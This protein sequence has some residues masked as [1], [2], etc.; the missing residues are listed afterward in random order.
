MG[1]VVTEK[2]GNKPPTTHLYETDL[3]AGLGATMH[4]GGHALYELG[5][6]RSE[7]GNGVDTA[8]SLGL[9]ESQSRLWE[10]FIGRS[11]PFL[12]WFA[13]RLRERVPGCDVDGDA[14]YRGANRIHPGHIRI[15]ADEVTYNLHVIIRFEL[16]LALVEG[17]LAVADL[18]EAW[19]AAYRETLGVEVTNPVDGVLQDVHWSNGTIGYFPT[20]TLGNLY[21]AALGGALERTFP[22][23]W[24]R[25]GRAD[26]GEIL[27]WLRQNVHVH[28]HA[29]DGARIVADA[30][31][32]ADLVDGLLD[33]LWARHGALLGLARR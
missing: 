4:E 14:L 28:G 31:G 13:E 24:D 18:P 23:L 22:D 1:L 6:P 12:G 5:I 3:L 33:Y 25:V 17:R 8:A 7:L 19:N 21:A 16:E 30:A 10:N 27:S 32:E 9:H 20:Y 15:H 26:L 29:R 2:K 11:R